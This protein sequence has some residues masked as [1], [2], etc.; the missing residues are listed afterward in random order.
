MSD[1]QLGRVIARA[2]KNIDRDDEVVAVV[3]TLIAMY[4]ATQQERELHEVA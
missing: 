3:E 4:A 2:V 1:G